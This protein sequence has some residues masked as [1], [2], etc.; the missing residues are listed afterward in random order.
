MRASEPH[1]SRQRICLKPEYQASSKVQAAAIDA[2]I[3]IVVAA[4][5]TIFFRPC[6]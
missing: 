1:G 6:P 3:E 5:I 4:G 2:L